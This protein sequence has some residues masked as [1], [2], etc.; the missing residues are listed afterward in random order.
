[1]TVELKI[2]MD[3]HSV[4]SQTGFSKD[5]SHRYFVDLHPP[6]FF[7]AN[8]NIMQAAIQKCKAWFNVYFCHTA[9]S[10]SHLILRIS[11]WI[12][13]GNRL[14][15]LYRLWSGFAQLTVECRWRRIRTVP[16]YRGTPHGSGSS[17]WTPH[18]RWRCR[19]ALLRLKPKDPRTA[20]ARLDSN[21]KRRKNELRHASS[22]TC[23]LEPCENSP[24]PCCR[25]SR[26][27]APTM[28]PMP[29]KHSPA[30]TK[31]TAL[32]LTRRKNQESSRTTGMT[33]QSNSW[34]EERRST[35]RWDEDDSSHASSAI[36][37][38]LPD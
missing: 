2:K 34:E 23:G 17:R 32:Y 38:L 36:Q 26:T 24:R 35:N 31:W 13:L 21:N 37:I 11:T 14:S 19:T 4:T 3:E 29:S 5:S 9:G 15:H 27:S 7:L 28:Q 18:T 1:M 22:T 33:K 16:S 30:P 20:S 12:Q 10:L 8:P 25:P 6:I